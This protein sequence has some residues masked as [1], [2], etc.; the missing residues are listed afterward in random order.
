S[1]PAVL[2]TRNVTWPCATVRLA[3]VSLK[4]ESLTLSDVAASATPTAAMDSAA[5]AAGTAAVRGLVIMP[6]PD[7]PGP[8]FLPTNRRTCPDV[9]GR[10]AAVW[11]LS[12]SVGRDVGDRAHV[13]VHFQHVPRLEAPARVSERFFARRR[14]GDE[15]PAPL[16][17][18][19]DVGAYVHQR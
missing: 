13:G 14:R 7:T 4:S 8:R 2:L 19:A 17:G 12:L 18:P 5:T 3:G 6:R 11:P 16:P 10:S 9:S 1:S 15:D